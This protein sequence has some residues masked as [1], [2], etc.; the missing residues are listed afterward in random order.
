MNNKTTKTAPTLKIGQTVTW[1]SG[2]NGV[3]KAKTGKIV[4]MI[5]AGKTPATTKFPT[6]TTS[7]KGRKNMSFVIEANNGKLYWPHTTQ[8]Q[9][10]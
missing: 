6:L 3:M 5:K 7:G 10:A 2:A 9:K 4:A 8:L 1:K